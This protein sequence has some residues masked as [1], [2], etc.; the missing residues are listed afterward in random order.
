MKK[1]FALFL[2]VAFVFTGLVGCGGGQEADQ[3]QPKDA[4][5]PQE[6]S[7]AIH[8][9]PN[10]IE[11]QAAEKF[12]EIIEDKSGGK[13]DVKLFPGA[14]LG[15]EKDNIEQLKVNE[16]QMSIFGDILPSVLAPEYA[17]TVI[18]FIFP[19]IDAVYEAWD[20]PIGEGMKKDIEENGLVV[21]GLQER[22]A[23]N[24]TSDR[25]VNTPDD[26]KG[27]KIRVPEIPTWVAVWKELGAIPTPIAWPEVYN[28]LQLKVVNAQEN[29]YANIT[30]A[31]LYEVQKYLVH[32]RHLINVFHWA[33]SKK[34]YDS[35]SAED[36]KLMMDTVKEVTAWA[37]EETAASAD[38]LLQEIK[39]EGMEVIDVDTS[40]FS[41]KA[42]PAIEEL[43]KDWAPGVYDEVKK[44]LE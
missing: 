9:A 12:K 2:I 37:D 44:F 29:P 35:L 33:G 32:T 5:K 31:K 39:D 23:R 7:I 11:H 30:S 38:K 22:G 4:P 34:W 15:G 14:T 18:P 26:L 6:I 17:V 1:V 24:L 40:A 3:E 8:T 16:V 19:D 43:S 25:P 42:L 21:M 13:Y 41:K 36:Q 28:A 27:L 10:T 20:G